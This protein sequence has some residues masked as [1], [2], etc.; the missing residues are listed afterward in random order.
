MMKT[1]SRC[2]Q[3]MLVCMCMQSMMPTT[4]L[5][6]VC[7]NYVKAMCVSCAS[8]YV[9]KACSPEHKGACRIHKCGALPFATAEGVK[10]CT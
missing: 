2:A 4:V 9:L 7:A 6:V 10:L 8:C 5:F 1:S 3:A